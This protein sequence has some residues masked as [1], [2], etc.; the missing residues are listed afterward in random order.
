M[1]A[2]QASN[3]PAAK[4]LLIR[5]LC[6]DIDTFT[7]WQKKITQRYVLPPTT[8][9]SIRIRVIYSYSRRL[10]NTLKHQNLRPKLVLVLGDLHIPHRA[11]AIPAAFEKLLVPGR[12]H[13]VLC[14]G[15]V[16][17][18]EQL[19]YLKTLCGNVHCVRGDF[20]EI[21]GLPETKVVEIGEFK[22]GLCHGHQIVP[23]GDGEA[24]GALQRKLGVDILISGHT[25]QSA[26]VEKN[27]TL[28][29]NPGSITGAYSS[30]SSKSTPSFITMAM[31][32]KKVINYVYELVDGKK[33]V[34]KIE[35]SKKK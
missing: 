15:N 23:W 31:N 4:A 24:L 30:L 2:L 34:N 10:S 16:C 1:E 7:A 26:L 19:D 28:F 13:H 18:D 17:T 22:I 9:L 29:I 6:A 20:D 21:T 14:T 35:F 32:G 3:T 27:G 5:G 11:N 25:H 8:L 12:V 33:K